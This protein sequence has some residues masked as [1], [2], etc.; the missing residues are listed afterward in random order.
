[1]VCS[2]L[3]AGL[4]IDSVTSAWLCLLCLDVVGENT[5]CA[6]VT[7]SFWLILSYGAVL[8]L[9]FPDIP[10]VV[11]FM[12]SLSSLLRSKILQ[13]ILILMSQAC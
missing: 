3:C 5:T 10:I 4:L 8:L 9:L 1:M 12:P 13:A 11:V 7:L 6:K 2:L